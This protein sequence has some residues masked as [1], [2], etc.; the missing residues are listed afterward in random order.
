MFDVTEGRSDPP[1]IAQLAVFLENRV[2]ALLAL[3]RS[4]DGLG[5][6]LASVSVIDSVDHAVARLVVERPELAYET[7]RADGYSIVESE[8]LGVALPDGMGIRG[9][10]SALL[11]AELNVHYLYPLVTSSSLGAV[12]AVYV[13]EPEAATR[14]LN[15]KGYELIAHD[16]LF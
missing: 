8:L 14:V 4:L 2:G 1:R 3:T 13:E 12:L 5:L 10:L 7:L 9:V 6:S 11:L 15:E 16:E